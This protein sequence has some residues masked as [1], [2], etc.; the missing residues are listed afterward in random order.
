M[1]LLS[2]PTKLHYHKCANELNLLNTCHRFKHVKEIGYSQ[3]PNTIVVIQLHRTTESL[4][5]DATPL[6]S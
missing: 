4:T 6:L 3:S 1:R 2:T 5:N